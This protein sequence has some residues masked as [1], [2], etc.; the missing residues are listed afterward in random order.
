MVLVVEVEADVGVGSGATD[1]DGDLGAGAVFGEEGIDGF[2]EPGFPAGDHL[3]DV[4][5]EAGQAGEVEGLIVEVVDAVHG[6]VG[7]GDAVVEGGEG[8]FAV[9]E[10]E[11]TAHF[12]SDVG[13]RCLVLILILVGR[14]VAG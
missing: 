14:A 4:G 10:G 7:A 12:G 13:G 11:G 3:G 9:G 8:D 6:D 1:F 2:E 5:V